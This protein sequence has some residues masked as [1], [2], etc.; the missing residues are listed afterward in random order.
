M[1]HLKLYELDHLSKDPT[2]FEHFNDRL[3]AFAGETL[4]LIDD[5]IFD[6]PRDFR[7]LLT[8]RTTFINPM[9]ASIYKV[10]APARDDFGEARLPD[11]TQRAGLLGHV[12][13]LATHAHSRASSATRRGLAVRTILLCQSIPS[14]PVDVDTSIP[15][16]SAEQV[17]EERPVTSS[18]IVRRLPSTPIQ[19]DL[20][21]KTLVASDAFDHRV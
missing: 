12:S 17:R 5:L 20:D 6:H 3:G 19:L 16:P 10:P 15:E 8:S 18:A 14:P 9:L 7:E 1:I 11:S 2:V 21:L 13:F 4:R